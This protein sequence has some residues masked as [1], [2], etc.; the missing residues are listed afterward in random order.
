MVQETAGLCGAPRVSERI[1]YC[2]L[3]GLLSLHTACCDRPC[4]EAVRPLEGDSD[5]GRPSDE[6][7]T[8]LRATLDVLFTDEAD[9]GVLTRAAFLAAISGRRRLIACPIDAITASL[10]PLL[11]P[12]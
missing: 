8:C 2:S 1:V 11:I 7:V 3:M 9:I 12:W 4:K 5:Y 6:Q 10:C